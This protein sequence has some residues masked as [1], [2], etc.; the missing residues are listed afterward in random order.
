MRSYTNVREFA[1]Q[2]G[3]PSVD[4]VL[5]NGAAHVLHAPFDLRRGHF[6]R[7]VNGLRDQFVIVR[8]H[9]E[10]VMQF[11]AG[12]GKAAQDEH[13]AFVIARRHVL[14]GHQVHAVVQ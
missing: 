3:G 1:D 8:I 12:A 2:V 5:A 10:R 14:L 7:R 4:I 11:A 9:D 13:A 6:E